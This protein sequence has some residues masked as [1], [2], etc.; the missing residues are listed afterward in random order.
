[1][2]WTPIFVVFSL[3]FALIRYL[4]LG[5][6]ESHLPPGPRTLPFLG[7][8]HVLPTKYPHYKFTEWARQYGGIYS[9]K[10]GTGTIIVL[11]SMDS[12]KELLDKR[13]ATTASRPR[14]YPSE[15]VT[16]GLF[17]P[18]IPY[19]DLWRT[20]RKILNKILVPSAVPSH[21]PIQRAESFQLLFDV[22]HQPQDL[23]NHLSR[24]SFSLVTSIIYGK[25]CP[26]PDARE[27]IAFYEFQHVWTKL[28]SPGTVPPVDKLPILDYI[29]ER[30]ASWKALM[31]EVKQRHRELYFGL[32]DECERRM[33]SIDGGNGCFMEN[34]LSRKE[35]YGMDRE[36][37]G[38]LGG[39][40]IEAGS[41]TTSSILKSL[42]L[43]LAAS[44]AA[45]QKAS[46]EIRRVVGDQRSPELGDYEHLPYVGAILKEVHRFRPVAPICIPRETTATEE[47][48]G[49]TIPEGT[50]II[51]NI[52]GVFHNPEYF[53]DPHLFS[54]E[55]Y[56]LTPHGTKPGV[57]DSAFRDDL[58][59]GFGRRA[60]PGIHLAKNS[61]V[62]NAMN[63]IWAFEFRPLQDP[64]TGKDIPVDLF[65]YEEGLSFTPKTFQCRIT[66]R[67]NV[68]DIIEHQ[69]REATG[70]FV[71]LERDLAVEDRE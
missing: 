31:R 71:R 19:N 51:P 61:L 14:H 35:E 53:E 64:E 65:A 34:L 42:V 25:R 10:V 43:C 28:A 38:Y 11:S 18:L 44:P 45:Q 49:Y 68:V 50:T 48:L 46:E 55:R 17:L 66:P 29:P 8:I 9:L 15:Q 69:Y 58:A 63:L 7:N 4:K 30:W 70:T 40:M 41:E 56:L 54:P 13:N 52:Y 67:E 47:Y 1:M 3:L 20:Q 5:Q 6:R 60:C 26:R 16:N 12:I 62:L 21:L 37:I 39:T 36:Q 24:Y 2:S 32:F 57:D 23:C 59:F 27:M 22:L 33:S